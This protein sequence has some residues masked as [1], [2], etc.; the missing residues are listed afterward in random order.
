MS[1]TLRNDNLNPGLGSTDGDDAPGAISRYSILSAGPG[2]FSS[3]GGGDGDVSSL[4]APPSPGAN[5]LATHQ[6]S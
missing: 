2:S 1:Y 5:D 6:R 3:L 4:S